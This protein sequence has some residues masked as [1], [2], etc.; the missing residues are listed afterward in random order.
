MDVV[1]KDESIF[2]PAVGLKLFLRK[3]DLVIRSLS[4]YAPTVR[5]FHACPGDRTE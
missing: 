2:L 1:L 3:I 5:A 4:L